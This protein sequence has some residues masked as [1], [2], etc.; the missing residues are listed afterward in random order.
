MPEG[1]FLLVTLGKDLDQVSNDLKATAPYVEE[2][3]GNLQSDG[4]FGWRACVSGQ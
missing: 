4:G 2:R 1:F 3:L